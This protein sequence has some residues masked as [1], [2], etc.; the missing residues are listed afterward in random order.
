MPAKPRSVA[1]KAGRGEAGVDT[2]GQ[3][4][5]QGQGQSQG[6]GQGQGHPGLTVREV[7]VGVQGLLAGVC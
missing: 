2:Q 6:Q 1:M 5:G 4:Q 7:H 3:S